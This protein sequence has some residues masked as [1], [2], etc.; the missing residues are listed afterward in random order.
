M[1][2]GGYSWPLTEELPT[3]ALPKLRIKHREAIVEG[4]LP[5]DQELV[6]TKIVTIWNWSLAYFYH[7][8]DIEDKNVVRTK[9]DGKTV[10]EWIETEYVKDYAGDTGVDSWKSYRF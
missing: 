4:D 3:I 5:S 1:A 9:S 6:V 2:D 8:I 7:R 10:R